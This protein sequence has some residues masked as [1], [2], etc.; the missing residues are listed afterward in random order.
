[1]YRLYAP[2]FAQLTPAA[3]EQVRKGNYMRLFD[4]GQAQRQGLGEGQRQRRCN[5]MTSDKSLTAL[6]RRKW[7]GNHDESTTPHAALW[8][9]WPRLAVTI[10]AWTLAVRAQ[11]TPVQAADQR[12]R[13]KSSSICRK[14]ERRLHPGPRE[15]GSQPVR[16]RGRSPPTAR[17]FTAG[18]T[19]TEVSIQSISKVFTMAQCH[20]G[21]GAG[22]DREARSASMPPGMRF[23]S[24]VA[25]ELSEEAWRGP[26]NER[27]G[28]PGRDYRDQHGAGRRRADDDLGEDHRHRTTTS[29]AAS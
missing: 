18:D 26:G 29:P 6:R 16:D 1:M 7:E 4:E 10:T 23:N 20:P 13:I 24:I 27:A 9:R 22:R 14:E 8:R 15:G 21:P 5:A 2:L 28:Q 19:K 25:V 12:A 3:S 11:T 17:S